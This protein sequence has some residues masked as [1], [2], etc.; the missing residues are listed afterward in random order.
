MLVILQKKLYLILKYYVSNTTW[1]I[2]LVTLVHNTGIVK[3]YNVY[4]DL[5][6]SHTS[7]YMN[8]FD[9]T[10]YIESVNNIF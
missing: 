5:T 2:M 7:I 6:I 4:I 1:N 8:C 10:Y 9:L 3:K